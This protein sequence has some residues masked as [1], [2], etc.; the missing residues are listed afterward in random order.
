MKIVFT[1]G[2]T[3]GHFYPL[4]AVAEAVRERE[5][6][7]KLVGVSLYFMSPTPFDQK[8][9]EDLGI[10]YI[11]VTS[12]KMRVSFSLSNII[13]P[14]KVVWGC[15]EACIKL[16]RIYPDVV[17][18]KGGWGAFPVTIAS[19]LLRI[20]LIIHE[21]DSVP[22]KV[23]AISARWASRIAVAYEETATFFPPEK[24]AHTGLPL[25][26]SITEKLTEG[27]HEFLHL[28]RGIPTLLV[29]GGSQGSKIIN[30][31]IIAVLPQLLEYCQVVH[32]IGKSWYDETTL[33]TGATLAEHPHK[34][35]Y[36]PYPYLYPLALRMA[37]G[38]SHLVITRAGS[39]LFEI[40]AWGV[41]ALVIPISQS[42]GDHQK[43]NA[44]NYARMGA[45]VVIEEKNLS[46]AVFLEEVTRIL[47]DANIQDHLRKGALSIE[48]HDAST[49]IADELIS[50]GLSHE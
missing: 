35:R 10:R 28:E 6:Q 34:D 14:F 26:R 44:Y 43:K 2:G 1:G 20:P 21:S 16:F 45:G 49:R 39:M 33:L 19:R 27:A 37:A 50:I 13:D 48:S 18:S 42:R 15:I 38:V 46:D 7:Q 9:L 24:V 36:H 8:A 5:A 11:P 22:G 12:G 25:R 41:P 3:G 29:V 23:N 4:I 32:Q 17:F 40:A 31:Q 30:E 47:K